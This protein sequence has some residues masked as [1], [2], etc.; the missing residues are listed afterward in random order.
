LKFSPSLT[1]TKI[2]HFSKLSFTFNLFLHWGQAQ[3]IPCNLH[4]ILHHLS[5]GPPD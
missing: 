2:E 4:E 1:L 5:S 3:F